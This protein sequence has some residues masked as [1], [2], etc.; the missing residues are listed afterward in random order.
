MFLKLLS[1]SFAMLNMKDFKFI[2]NQEE[3]AS[4]LQDVSGCK[5]VG[6]DLEFDKNRFSYGFT[7]SLIQLN[8]NGK[9][10]MI[11]A[12]KD[13]DLTQVFAVFT[14]KSI[15]KV[16][17]A[18][19]E[20][21]RLLHHIGC[22]PKNIYDI[23]IA[24]KL[25]GYEQL[26]LSRL[27]EEV[28][29]LEEGKSSQK[30][31]WLK[32]PLT[33]SQLE[34]A[35]E[36]VANLFGLQASL[37]KK[38][39]GSSVSAWLIEENKQ[40]EN[41][42]FSNEVSFAPI[43]NKDKKGLTEHEFFLFEEL[44]NYRES[45]AENS[46][47]PG[48]RIVSKELLLKLAKHELKLGKFMSLKEVSRHFKNKEIKN[49]IFELFRDSRQKAKAKGL[50]LDEPVIKRLSK[51]EYSALQERKRRQQKII[52]SVFIPVKEHISKMYSK[53]TA[54]F[55]LSNKIQLQ[56][57][58]NGLSSVLNYKSSLITTISSELDLPIEL[59]DL[60]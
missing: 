27:T 29:G 17:F 25:L 50:D 12:L 14:D 53:E 60:D 36:D 42:D 31:N 26:S 19:G 43:K 11:D 32:R 39:E 6:L 20:D 41:F 16:V 34:Y 15:E 45:I 24:A 58:N 46:S 59:L 4:A 10:L 52:N 47:I 30:S 2:D 18:F 57:I 51:E 48:Y 8:F 13:L 37:E 44:M 35:A 33:P 5:R 40:Y 21:I 7:L 22:F 23:A 49:H 9:V 55:I 56:I 54:S 3:L 38:M 1:L 28:L